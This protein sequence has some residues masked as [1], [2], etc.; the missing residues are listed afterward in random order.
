M[1]DY[2]SV[3]PDELRRIA[4]QHD[5]AA[6]K[7]RAWGE[8]PQAWLDEYEDTYGTIA[9]PMHAALVDY[10]DDRHNKAERLAEN[11]ERT[12]DEL[13]AAAQ[14]LED[15][16]HSSAHDIAQSGG[17][18][19]QSGG[20]GHHQS[21]GNGHHQSGGNGQGASPGDPAPGAPTDPAAR[22]NTGPDT[23]TVNGAQPWQTAVT[24]PGVPGMPDGPVRFDQAPLSPAASAAPTSDTARA[25]TTPPAVGI[26]ERGAAGIPIA[27]AVDA[28]MAAMPAPL[29]TGPYPT[30]AAPSGA[31]TTARPPAPLRAGPFAA[32]VHTADNRRT[33]PS[34]LVGERVD[35]DL[36]LARTLLGAVL[37]A[38]R[39]SA[40]GVE[41][42][43]AVGRSPGGPIVLLTST[44]GR[45][46][47]PPGLFLP[48][49]VVLPWRWDSILRTEGRMA[50]A[51]LEGTTDPARML[52][53]F[54]L[55]VG[56]RK[57]ARI[58]ALVSSAAISDGVRAAVGDDC[59]FD[60]WVAA[61]ES[62]IDFTAPGAGLVDRLAL[63]GSDELLN[64]AA[65]VPDTQI[66][67][68]CLELARAADA[69][70]RTIF[71]IDGDATIRSARR[72]RILD[73]LNAGQP[74]PPNWW[75]QIRATDDMTA[76]AVRSQ[77]VDVSYVPVGG[78]HPGSS[79][80]E[81]LRAMVFQRRA[82]E[83][84]LLLAA[85]EPDR[86]TL[87][88][89]FYTYGQIVEHPLL[90]GA[91]QVAAVQTAGTSVAVP[92]VRAARSVGPGVP[93]V[94]SISVGSTVLGGAPPSMAE[95]L[96]RPAGFEGSSEQR[97]V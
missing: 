37:A 54:G 30:S 27:S 69:R 90:P 9:A 63:A 88:D 47:L 97:R 92:G 7:L 66:R 36:A 86:Q 61:E 59:A 42:A 26:P 38:V 57:K 82:D 4:A 39:D 78:M 62:A 21:G 51:A 96:R 65:T 20:N 32:A 74:I 84:L 58:S 79:G 76:A 71:D 94:N 5:L 67:A 46:W 11:H 23:P 55:L 45:G 10:Y 3:D 29:A 16:D 18:G 48:L 70:V 35:E 40:L 89:A 64:Q 85:G 31:G 49:E 50:F 15:G 53:E 77:R 60:E 44:E 93:S 80:T 73:V 75:D 12:R 14:A 68:T 52:A 13:L 22:V 34:L 95:L 8:I 28:S 1:P 81:A 24:T 87:R 25:G 56:R 17:N 43:V 2:M 91:T 33:L 6:A 83:L 72:Q 41:W 19:H